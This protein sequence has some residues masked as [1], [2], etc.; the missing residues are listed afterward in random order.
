MPE[1]PAT[2]SSDA[3]DLLR[4]HKESL[5]PSVTLFYDEPVELRSG[6][7]QYVFDGEGRQYLDFFDGITFVGSGHA[8]SKST[9]RSRR[10]S[11]RSR[12]PRPCS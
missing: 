2:G 9:M 11:T 10:S 8:V 5:F 3:A 6:E 1:F 12:I 7:G 4:R